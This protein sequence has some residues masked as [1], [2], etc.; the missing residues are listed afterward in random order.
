MRTL[1]ILSSIL[2]LSAPASAQMIVLGQGLS[3]TC[4]EAAMQ[5]DHVSKTD[6]ETC[7]KA[8]TEQNA[9]YETRLA[10]RVNRGILLMRDGNHDHALKDFNTALQM[11]DTLGTTY[12]NKGAVLIHKANYSDAMDSLN[13]A[14]ELNSNDLHAA[15]YNRAL[16]Y[17]K[18]GKLTEAY[19]DLK[20][21]L[22]LKPDFQP[23][24]DQI[25]RYIV[26]K[27]S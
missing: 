10:T 3:R 11:D 12:L 2:V 15:Y 14:I 13:K 9:S 4:Y 23:A 27:A 24:I 17:E 7:T 25:D 1:V 5:G 21:A 19:Y 26:E 16:V 22:E 6:I 8:L 20:K 18:Q